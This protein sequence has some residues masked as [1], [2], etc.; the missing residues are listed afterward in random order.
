[1]SLIFWRSK[2]NNVTEQVSEENPFPVQVVEAIPG[3]ETFATAN[4]AVTVADTAVGLTEAKY[5]NSVRAFITPE[6]AQIRFY[7]HGPVPTSSTGHILD[8][9][10]PLVLD[11][12]DAI[13]N[14]RAIRT[15]A[16]S[17]AITATYEQRRPVS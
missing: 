3:T 15:G 4:E 6:T 17:A 14:F 7:Y 12:I 13:K 1:M 8:P 16:T 5:R 9:G 2:R 10:V 11:G